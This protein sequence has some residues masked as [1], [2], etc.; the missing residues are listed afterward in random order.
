M[1]SMI[2]KT[3]LL[4]RASHAALGGGTE[5]ILLFLTCLVSF[6]ATVLILLPRNPS[7]S[8]VKLK[9]LDLIVTIILEF[10]ALLLSTQE[11]DSFAPIADE[12]ASKSPHTS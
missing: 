8:G 5:G 9:L 2:Y 3:E 11:F 10:G 1:L 7:V 6:G 4:V 12:H